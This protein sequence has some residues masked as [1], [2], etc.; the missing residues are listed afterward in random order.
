MTKT[1][2]VAGWETWSQAETQESQ[3]PGLKERLF[4][5]ESYST[6]TWVVQRVC[7]GALLEE[8]GCSR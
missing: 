7:G 1:C 2:I 8:G 5:C 6:W 4:Y 3:S